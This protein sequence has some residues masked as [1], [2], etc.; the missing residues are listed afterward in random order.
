MVNMRLEFSDTKVTLFIDQFNIGQ[1][2]TERVTMS[3]TS[4][5]LIKVILPALH[6]TYL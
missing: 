6:S 2:M 3:I 1:R 4:L 5:M